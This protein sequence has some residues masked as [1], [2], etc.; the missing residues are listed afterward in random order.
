[1]PAVYL[2]PPALTLLLLCAGL[3]L[4]LWWVPAP[5]PT[6]QDVRPW[7][8]VLGVQAL[9]W[10]LAGYALARYQLWFDVVATQ[11]ASLALVL[12]LYAV[13][14]WRRLP[15]P[16]ALYLAP[17]A[18]VVLLSGALAVEPLWRTVWTGLALS[19][20]ALLLAWGV[21]LGWRAGEPGGGT[22]RAHAL[23]W[24]GALGWAVLHAVQALAALWPPSALLWPLLYGGHVLA[25]CATTLGY[26]LW[27]YEHVQRGHERWAVVDPV[28]AVTHQRATLQALERM[29]SLARRAQ[30]PLALLYVG[31][32]DAERARHNTAST[33]HSDG[34]LAAVAQ[35]L[36]LRLRTHDLLGHAGPDAFWV[37]LPSTDVGGALVVADDMRTLFEREPLQHHG[38]ALRLRLSIGVHG[39]VPVDGTRPPEAM[40]QAA[41]R[42]WQAARV[43]GGNRIEIEA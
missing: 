43:A 7:A 41:Q 23:L 19:A 18:G 3:A 31:L 12:A 13:A 28:T 9:H 24:G 37:V 30:Q 22:T 16:V 39:Q 26:V 1:M 20:Q 15:L 25:L 36:Q 35:R 2:P 14:R 33:P 17:L 40:A 11:L 38:Q 21:G 34:L 32:D 29:W 6:G 10:G 8:A 27:Q 5:R 42:A 4:A